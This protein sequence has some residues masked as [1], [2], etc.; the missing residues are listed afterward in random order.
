[1]IGQSS[2]AQD[3]LRLEDV[4]ELLKESGIGISMLISVFPY[5]VLVLHHL[6]RHASGH[7][8]RT[9]SRA[10]IGEKQV[11]I[12]LTQDV[13]IPKLQEQFGQVGIGVTDPA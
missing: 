11:R 1:M 4:T 9:V 8:T 10:E 6:P 5:G 3:V 2:K 7:G 13:R 12:A